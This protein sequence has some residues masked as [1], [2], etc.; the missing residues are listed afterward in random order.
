MVM[1][2]RDEGS[3]DPAE[4]AGD[5]GRYGRFA[6]IDGWVYKGHVKREIETFYF[7]YPEPSIFVPDTEKCPFLRLI[8]LR[9]E[10]EK[11]LKNKEK[12]LD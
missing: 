1:D 11:A 9:Y 6:A 3:W 5:P 12:G 2:R 10:T 7:V 8:Y 4:K